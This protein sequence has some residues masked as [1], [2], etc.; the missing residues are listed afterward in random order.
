M[1]LS[2]CD[3]FSEKASGKVCQLKKSLI[4]FFFQDMTGRNVY[5]ILRAPRTSSMESLVLNIPYRPLDSI[6]PSTLPGL[7]LAM[8]MLK[9]FRRKYLINKKLLIKQGD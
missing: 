2:L 1:G 7:A 6:Y 5:A 9:F 8:S 4:F 3:F